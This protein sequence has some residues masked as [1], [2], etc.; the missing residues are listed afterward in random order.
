MLA[1]ACPGGIDIYFE[2]VGGPISRRSSTGWFWGPALYW[3]SARLETMPSGPIPQ[4]CANISPPSPVRYSTYCRPASR[5]LKT[6]LNR[7]LRSTSGRPRRLVP[8]ISITS[9][10]KS[11]AKASFVRLRSA[12][13][14]ETSSALR[15]ATSPSITIDVAPRELRMLGRGKRQ[16]RPRR[17][18][19]SRP[20]D[21]R[22]HDEPQG[23]RLLGLYV[24]HC[25][26][27]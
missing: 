10:A 27:V 9:K 14:S 19:L 22:L 23:L 13:K 25:G 1:A 7:P 8:S 26:P 12:S 16:N 18:R 5:R 21:F 11:H 15:Q 17:R 20:N 24:D 6:S 3:L 2:N 4:A